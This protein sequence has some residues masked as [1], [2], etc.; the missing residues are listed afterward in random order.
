MSDKSGFGS[1]LFAGMN[2]GRSKTSD[3]SDKAF[4]SSSEGDV[5]S[6][7]EED[8]ETS[9]KGIFKWDSLVFN[10]PKRRGVLEVP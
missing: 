8:D 5:K 9:S 3:N 10:G 1:S 7:L 6:V 2:L 4:T